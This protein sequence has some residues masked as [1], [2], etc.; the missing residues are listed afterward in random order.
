MTPEE[1]QRLWE[2]TLHEDLLFSDRQ[3]L[4]LVAESFLVAAH[5]GALGPETRSVALTIAAFGLAFTLVWAFVSWRQYLLVEFIQRQ[6]QLQLREYREICAARPRSRLR[7]RVLVAFG[8]PALVF[9]LWV[10]LFALR[11]T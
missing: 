1:E 8:L 10:V 6:A 3:N 9:A 2:W 11:V 5:A 4:F 7:S